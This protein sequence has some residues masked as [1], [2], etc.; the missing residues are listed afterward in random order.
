MGKD[1]FHEELED[2]TGVLFKGNIT[3]LVYDL[4]KDTRDIKGLLKYLD[5]EVP[6]DTVD[7]P[8]HHSISFDDLFSASPLIK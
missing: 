3:P 5:E 4:L 8:K 2:L 7:E 1:I 6:N